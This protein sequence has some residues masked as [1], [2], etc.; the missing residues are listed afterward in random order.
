MINSKV[1]IVNFYNH[2]Y[3]NKI[4]LEI[5]KIIYYNLKKSLRTFPKYNNLLGVYS[6]HLLKFLSGLFIKKK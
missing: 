3:E 6:I 2:E 5:Y 1:Q 4:N